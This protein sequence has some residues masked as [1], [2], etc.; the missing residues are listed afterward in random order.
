MTPTPIKSDTTI[1]VLGAGFVGLSTASLLANAGYTV[2]LIEPNKAR[3]DIIKTGRSFFFEEGIN[4]LIKK[5][6]D[7][8]KLIP[9]DSYD[10]SVPHSSIVFSCVGTPDNPDGSSNLSYVF[11]SADQA[12]RL[13]TNKAVYVQKSTVP[14][15]TGNRIME[16]ID[17]VNPALRYVSNPEFLRES[18][19]LYDTLYFDRVVIGGTSHEANVRIVECYQQLERYRDEI[20]SIAGIAISKS[21]NISGRYIET[22]LNSAELIKVTSN[23][24]LALKISFANSIAKLSDAVSADITEVM[25]GVGAD[26]RIGRSFLNA[27]RGYGGGC[28]PKDVSGLIASGLDHGIDLEIMQTAQAVNASM[29][30]Y[31][32]EKLKNALGGELV[33]KKIAV[34]G[35]AFKA[36]TSDVRKSPGV[37]IANS[38]SEAGSV[39]IA[40]DPEANQEASH[41]LRRNITLVTSAKE[42]L[43]SADAVIIATD[44]PEYA[45]FTAVAFKKYMTSPTIVDALNTYSDIENDT[46]ITYIGVGR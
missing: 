41:D 40:H 46:D 20:A 37:S 14:V 36:G 30:G 3:L 24:F 26:K 28:F 34:L 11:D 21:S 35:L 17:K 12:I 29:P 16:L 43:K 22:S 25:D 23:A 9:T 15:G 33:G 13:M 32:V 4:P 5:A 19:A 39:V 45:Q 27:G 38:L 42:A 6:I 1:T 8:K 44:W 31:I 10:K 18:T 7:S 2:Y